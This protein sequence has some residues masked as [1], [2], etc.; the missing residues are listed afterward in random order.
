M[1]IHQ[2]IDILQTIADLIITSNEKKHIA[3]YGGSIQLLSQAVNLDG[4]KI[5]WCFQGDEGPM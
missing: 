5:S 2:H 4:H 3:E 1:I